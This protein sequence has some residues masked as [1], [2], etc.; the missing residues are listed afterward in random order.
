MSGPELLVE[1][2][3][4]V[5]GHSETLGAVNTIREL[6]AV[7]IRSLESLLEGDRLAI[8]APEAP[9]SPVYERG[10]ERLLRL[11]RIH[12]KLEAR[13]RLLQET[14]TLLNDQPP[15]RALPV[16]GSSDTGSRSDRLV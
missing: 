7:E 6:L 16:A 11:R 12:A 14:C 8:R 15:G 2:N 1:N 4:I 10:Y 13:E 9:A 5:R 3:V